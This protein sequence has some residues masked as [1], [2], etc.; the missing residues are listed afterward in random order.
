MTVLGGKEVAQRIPVINKH[1]PGIQHSN[2]NLHINQE[3]MAFSAP[4]KTRPFSI[5]TLNNGQ[6]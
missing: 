6:P 2:P 1:I 3:P 4:P 5:P